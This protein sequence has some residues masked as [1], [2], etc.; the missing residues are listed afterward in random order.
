MCATAAE[1]LGTFA[2]PTM[3]DAYADLLR[4]P[5]LLHHLIGS[6]PST[7]SSLKSPAGILVLEGAIEVPPTYSTVL[8]RLDEFVSPSGAHD[9]WMARSRRASFLATRCDRTF[10]E[11]WVRRNEAFIRSISRPGLMLDAVGENQ[12]IVRLHELGLLSESARKRF[13]DG[14]VEY[15]TGWLDPSVLWD[16]DLASVLSEEQSEQVRAWARNELND[17]PGIIENHT[18]GVVIDDQYG[19]EES[20][21]YLRTLVRRLPSLFPS[22]DFVVHAARELGKLIDQW[23]ASHDFL[24]PVSPTRTHAEDL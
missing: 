8:D 18:E 24:E 17:L 4:N 2:H 9:A 10:L 7:S 3:V 14:L 22:D 16:R 23:V 13:A 21:T 5:E 12:I 15:C 19:S 1:R 11:Q 20:V 6:F